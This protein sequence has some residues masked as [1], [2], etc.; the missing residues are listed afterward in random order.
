MISTAHELRSSGHL[1]Q[2][3]YFASQVFEEY[4]TTE[5]AIINTFYSFF[6]QCP[7]Y[8]LMYWTPSRT[9]QRIYATVYNL[10]AKYLSHRQFVFSSNLL[11][12]SRDSTAS[13]SLVDTEFDRFCPQVQTK[14]IY[15][16]NITFLSPS[17]NLVTINC[18]DLQKLLCI[19]QCWTH[20]SFY[21]EWEFLGLISGVSVSAESWSG[22]QV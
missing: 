22:D 19:N 21:Q 7:F 2:D 5:T 3:L 13:S 15:C 8:F 12:Q 17:K 6:S 14:K 1:H 11:T 10:S 18:G 4:W 20:F 9:V 16:F